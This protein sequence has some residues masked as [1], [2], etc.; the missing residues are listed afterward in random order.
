MSNCKK[1]FRVAIVAMLV[2]SG[3]WTTSLCRAQE[4]VFPGADEK[5]PSLAHYFTWINNT[6]EGS[7]ET[8]TMLNLD[9]FQW[10]HDEYGMILDIYAFDA[11]NIDGPNYYGSMKTDK[12]KKQFPNGFDPIYK[13]AKAMGTRLG[14]WLGPDGFGDT[15]GE[16]QARIDM[17]V[18]LCRD[19][20]FALFKV[21]AV[22]GQL[23]NEKQ[24][25]FARAMTE[26][27]KYSPDLIVLNHRLNLGDA[28]DHVTTELWGSE[29][30][31]DVHLPNWQYA[32][33]NRAAAVSRGLT[34]NL[35]RLRED[36][37]VCISSCLDYWDDDL[38]LQA[39]ARSLI[40]APETYGSPWFLRDE[41]YPKFARIYNL[42][43]RYRDIL[44]NGIVLPGSDGS[45]IP[46][47]NLFTANGEKG[48]LSGEYFNGQNFQ[49]PVLSRVDRG[50]NFDW[51]EDSPAAGISNNDFSVRWTGSVLTNQAGEYTFS[52]SSDDG[53]RLWVDNNLIIDDWNS[54]ASQTNT[55]KL[56]L[57]AKT[58]YPIKLEYFEDGGDAVVKLGWKEHGDVDYGPFAISR[59]DESTR[60]ISLRNLSWLPT[61]YKIKLDAAVGLAD[62]GLIEL[63]QF[64]PF[65]KIFG[66][67]PYGSQ[68]D[69]EVLPYRACLLLATTKPTSELGVIGC[70]YQVLR[71]TPGKPALIKLVGF[72]GSQASITLAPTTTKYAKATLDGSPV[73][74]F[75]DTVQVKFPGER[76]GQPWHR[77]LG[78]LKP[79]PV[80]ADAEALYEATCFAADNNAL[81]VRSLL[82]SGPTKIPQV[83]K[84][85]KAF[86]EQ[87]MFI[88]R[89]IWDKFLFDG[90]RQ[91]IFKARKEGGLFRLDFGKVIAIDKLLI[92]AA[93]G[94]FSKSLK[95]DEISAEVSPDLTTWMRIDIRVEKDII[96]KPSADKP[97]RYIRISGAPREIAEV[98]GY[99][100]NIALNRSTW[101][102]SNLFASYSSA[103]AVKAWSLSFTLPEAPKGT[104]LAIPL[105]GR[106]G[107]EGAYAAMRIGGEY[108]GAPSRAVSYQS[109][110][111]EYPV[112]RT[113]S[114]YTYYVPVTKEMLNKQ[115]EVVVLGLDSKNINF[116]PEAWITAYPIP[117]ETK[118]LLLIP[119]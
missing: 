5:T 113:D 57:K 13:K 117:F 36:H 47:S 96:A 25:A 23:R 37:G 24:P 93:D 72:P 74:I 41:E 92:G 107:S 39:F 81:E 59:G 11:G 26:C 30:Y 106:H 63:R 87:E 31:I 108:L 29:A 97:I 2:V 16:E 62:K 17:L 111:W 90:N 115:I 21:D 28:K 67:F 102:A 61:K 66:R 119:K 73:N 7:T 109:N 89:G 101:R 8:Q 83:R 43:R 51:E 85:R 98:E 54:H 45:N 75:Q 80:P 103:P 10:L 100:N 95:N 56:T 76:F 110:A 69:V 53:V 91:T 70:D 46:S 27:R 116:K 14:V 78:A 44:V 82:N 42:H 84:A 50:I 105:A 38:V 22:C 19:Y 55:G 33:H 9:F 32:P 49:T 94:D 20:E 18:K 71:D 86:M 88:D 1:F 58:K 114:N 118:E 68:V 4:K 99:R 65:E 34:E 64:H 60:L 52:T 104:Y 6:N 40:L 12:F 48:G 3:F 15:P 35:Q 77:K 112:S 79:C